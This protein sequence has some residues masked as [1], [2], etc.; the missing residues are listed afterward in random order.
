[1]R[2]TNGT[3]L[4]A[5]VM[6]FRTGSRSRR[7]SADFSPQQVVRVMQVWPHV[8]C[9]KHG[10][11]PLEGRWRHFEAGLLAECCGLK[12]ALLQPL[13]PPGSNI[14]DIPHAIKFCENRDSTTDDKGSGTRETIVGCHYPAQHPACRREICWHGVARA[15][16]P[17]SS[18]PAGRIA[19]TTSGV[20]PNLM[21]RSITSLN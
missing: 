7:C 18:D 5:S 1:M 21:T 17:V 15:I 13:V 6:D 10:D 12:S 2:D 11:V 16:L 3:Q 8:E 19:H 9:R 14:H 4:R 20:S